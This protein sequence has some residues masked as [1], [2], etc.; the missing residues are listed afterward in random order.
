VSA[1]CLQFLLVLLSHNHSIQG[2]HRPPSPPLPPAPSGP[3]PPS[4]HALP[5]F[6]PRPSTK[7]HENT[8]NDNRW[9]PRPPPSHSHNYKLN[10]GK[11]LGLLFVGIVISLQIGVVGLLVFKRRQLL[12]VKG[13]YETC[14]SSS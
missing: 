5:P 13:T 10:T 4:S 12:K 1:F 3:P 9:R 2:H 6:H 7:H 8:T 11:K 14:S